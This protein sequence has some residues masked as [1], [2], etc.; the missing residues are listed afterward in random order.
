MHSR[1]NYTEESVCQCNGNLM[2]IGVRPDLDSA[3]LKT[4]YRFS[5]WQ[6]WP[7]WYWPLE[8]SGPLS[9]GDNAGITIVNHP[10]ILVGLIL[11]FFFLSV[12]VWKMALLA[13]ICFVAVCAPILVLT[14]TKWNN[15]RQQLSSKHA[16]SLPDNYK[17]ED[18][19]LVPRVWTFSDC[20]GQK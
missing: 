14:L 15:K 5:V 9:R 17:H 20:A 10:Q 19:T 11:L 18:W 16:I 13:S 4:L 2:E 7:Y 8:F 3:C 12:T 6:Y 1:N